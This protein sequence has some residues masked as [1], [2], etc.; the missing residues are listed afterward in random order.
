ML[1]L[2][3]VLLKFHQMMWQQLQHTFKVAVKE[4]Q[5]SEFKGLSKS[6]KGFNR[7]FSEYWWHI[8]KFSIPFE[9]P[10]SLQHGLNLCG[11]RNHRVRTFSLAI[12]AYSYSQLL[13]RL[14]LHLTAVIMTSGMQCNLSSIDIL[15]MFL[16]SG[17][18]ARC[19]FWREHNFNQNWGPDSFSIPYI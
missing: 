1:I 9:K 3:L 17:D 8:T 19:D 11:W 7:L 6:R 2:T 15:P 12:M 5:C 13:F 4:L 14:I 10:F 16:L 18:K